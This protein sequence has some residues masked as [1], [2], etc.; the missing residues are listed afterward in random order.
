MPLT[1]E[2]ALHLLEPVW[3][4]LQIS[5]LR[6]DAL[7][8]DAPFT[9]SGLDLRDLNELQM[10]V[11]YLAEKGSRFDPSYLLQAVQTAKGTVLFFPNV[12]LS[13]GDKAS[14]LAGW[15]DRHP[16]AKE[17]A[18]ARAAAQAQRR[19]ELLPFFRQKIAPKAEVAS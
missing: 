15:M 1:R 5:K 18:D 10:A 12:A 19:A 14:S 7:M 9:G 17:E 13:D 6:A 16:K 11:D 3:W 8:H 4:G 2:Q